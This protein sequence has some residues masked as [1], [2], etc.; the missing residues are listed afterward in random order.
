[1]TSLHSTNSDMILAEARVR[2]DRAEIARA[3]TDL[4]SGVSNRAADIGKAS[5]GFLVLLLAVSFAHRH[6]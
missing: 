5:A 4:K 1:M 6:L 3:L 2:Q